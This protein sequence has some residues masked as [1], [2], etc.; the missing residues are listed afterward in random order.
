ML[1]L[2]CA[3]FRHGVYK[4]NWQQVDPHATDIPDDIYGC[5]MQ[6]QIINGEPKEM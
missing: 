5:G 4:S 6:F 1:E 2:N 3:I